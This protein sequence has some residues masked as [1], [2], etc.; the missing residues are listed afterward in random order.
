MHP[1]HFWVRIISSVDSSKQS[2]LRSR[3]RIPQAPSILFPFIINCTIFVIVPIEK[4]TTIN[5]KRLR[6]GHILGNIISKKP[7]TTSLIINLSLQEVPEF[8]GSVRNPDQSGDDLTSLHLRR[9]PL[10]AS[11]SPLPLMMMTQQKL[12]VRCRHSVPK[13]EVENV[14]LK[15]LFLLKSNRSWW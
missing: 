14:K 11:L 6:L 15:L 12:A 3:V 2:I 1:N 8:Y 4:R 7:G 13:W 9:R 10:T 5:K